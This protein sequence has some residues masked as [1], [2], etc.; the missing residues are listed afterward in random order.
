MRQQKRPYRMAARAEAAERTAQ[1]IHDA[2]VD[3]FRSR[4]FAEVTLQAVADRAEVT[5]QTVLRRFGSKDEL[6]EAAAARFAARVFESRVPP[7]AGDVG[8]AIEAL[9]ASYE[10]M[11]DLGWR[12]LCQEDQSGLVA[13]VLDGARAGHRRW[14]E[15]SFAHLL[16]ARAGAE[17]ERRV[18]LL[19][20]ATDFYQWKL[21]RRDL[22]RDRQ[23]TIRTM[24]EW[25]EALAGAFD[26]K[27]GRR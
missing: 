10:A 25:V 16:P 17:R 3:L 4:P 12:A 5:L 8:A 6:F 21:L 14:V 9:V 19:F 15:S 22:G 18:L 27:G 20:G 7:H 13:A 23:T 11:G 24:V 26:R 2:A 1:R